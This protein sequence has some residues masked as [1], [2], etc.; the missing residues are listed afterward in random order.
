MKDT[1]FTE[2]LTSEISLVMNSCLRQQKLPM[3]K[4]NGFFDQDL[5]MIII[6]CSLFETKQINQVE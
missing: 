1:T 2:K 3:T 4:L 6:I 5:F